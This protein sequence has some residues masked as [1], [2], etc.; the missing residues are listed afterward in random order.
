MIFGGRAA[1][2]ATA[3]R[4]GQQPIARTASHILRVFPMRDKG[5]PPRHGLSRVSTGALPMNLTLAHGGA[6]GQASPPN[7]V[8]RRGGTCWPEPDAPI[9]AGAAERVKPPQGAGAGSV[10]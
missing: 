7:D 1:S 8:C 9:V 4:E 10:L 2:A 3:A 6:Y 5:K